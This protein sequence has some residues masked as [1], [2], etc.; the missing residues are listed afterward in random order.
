MKN[1][2]VEKFKLNPLYG[3]VLIK[4]TCVE[5]EK[6]GSIIVPGTVKEAKQTGKVI[7]VGS[8]K[9]SGDGSIIPLQVKVGDTVLFE[10]Y[11]GT[12]FKDDYII[13]R[14]DELLATIEG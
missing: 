1:N 14:E 7:A 10:K 3:R 4:R 12:A 6:V 2:I 8:G 11:A 9:M 5:E 13:I